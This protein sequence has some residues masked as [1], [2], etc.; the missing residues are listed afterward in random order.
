MSL[1]CS[2]IQEMFGRVGV[3]VVLKLFLR[4]SSFCE[5]ADPSF[6]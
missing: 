4:F 2:E 5:E 3:H 6:H 1:D